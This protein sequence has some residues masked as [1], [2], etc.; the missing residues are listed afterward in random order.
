M[1]FEEEKK[2][3]RMAVP[4][5]SLSIFILIV[6]YW[7]RPS[8]QLGL[9]MILGVVTITSLYHAY[10][11][12]WV[13]DGWASWFLRRVAWVAGYYL[14]LVVLQLWLGGYG[15]VGLI[16]LVLLISAFALWRGRKLYVW[17]VRRGINFLEGKHGD[18]PK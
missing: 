6:F 17:A 11:Q 5:I 10:K 14:L 2:V 7:V 9:A 1:A 16:V 12:A 4:G 8:Y 15:W 18:R 13:V 3:M